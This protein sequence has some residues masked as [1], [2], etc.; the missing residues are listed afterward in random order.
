MN[1]PSNMILLV[2]F[3]LISSISPE[4]ISCD[5]LAVKKSF[6]QMII[7]KYGRSIFTVNA[8]TEIRYD[9]SIKRNKNNNQR[10]CQNVGTAF[11]VDNNGYLITFNSVIKDAK[12]VQVISSTGDK[13][14]ASVIGCDKSEKISV[15]K[16]DDYIDLSIPGESLS[17]NMNPG[18]EVILLCIKEIGLKAISGIISDI[19]PHYGTVIVNISGNPGTSGTPVFDK[20]QRLLGFLAYQIEKNGKEKNNTA[21]DN[22]VSETNSYLVISSEFAWVTARLIIN[23]SEGNCGWLGIA[24]SI[25]NINTPVKDGVVIKGIV[26]NSPAEKS[27][28][29]INDKIIKFNSIPI[30]SFVGLIEALTDTKAGDTVPIHFLRG[31]RILSS[32]VTLSAYPKK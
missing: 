26:K 19:R 6:S 9:D 28:L 4:K 10:W 25:N 8:Y 3:L 1:P 2:T 12:E 21:P 27:G 20:N 29:T 22:S 5:P 30:S 24:S 7:Q 23:K 11:S 31:D 15:L 14:K 17:N 18:D 32:D 13:I 16:I